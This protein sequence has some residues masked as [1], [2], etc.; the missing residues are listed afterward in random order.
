MQNYQGKEAYDVL[1]LVCDQYLDFA[2]DSH[3]QILKGI[4]LYLK[5][6]YAQALSIFMRD[7]LPEDGM[8][9]RAVCFLKTYAFIPMGFKLLESHVL[10][11]HHYPD[12]IQM[13]V[14]LDI[15]DTALD[16]EN[17]F[18]SEKMVQILEK[19]TKLP[20]QDMWYKEL[21]ERFI[22]TFSQPSSPKFFLQSQAYFLHGLRT[23]YKAE[24]F[25]KDLRWQWVN[26]KLS[27]PEL[28]E[29][30]LLLRQTWKHKPLAFE[31]TYLLAEIYQ[32]SQHKQKAL[33]EYHRYLLNKDVQKNPILYQRAW[34]QA[35]DLLSEILQQ[36]SVSPKEK[37]HTYRRYHEY[38][39]HE[40][41]RRAEIL[42][43]VLDAVRSSFIFQE[44]LPFIISE[45][46]KHLFPPKVWALDAVE[47]YRRLQRPKDAAQCMESW[48]LKEKDL[49]DAW[50]I[51]HAQCWKDANH[52]DK[53]LALL[54]QNTSI[55]GISAYVSALM[56]A[57]QW[58]K[59][60]VVT[61]RV[62]E[63]TPEPDWVIQRVQAAIFLKHFQELP[64]LREKYY[65]LM[66][67]TQKHFQ[68][69]LLLTH[70]FHNVADLNDLQFRLKSLDMLL[71]PGKAT[72]LA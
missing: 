47:I 29:R 58:Q 44:M 12:S 18:L 10:W 69:F 45:S 68:Q 37:I 7:D 40:L 38:F 17:R 5:Q 22:L 67:K 23:Y 24:A 1:S 64:L 61:D 56:D 39:P 33:E 35:S 4:S 16:F 63:K 65:V 31:A 32:N 2:Q 60:I 28:I 13:A 55:K 48:P 21:R 49:N 66:K 46:K 42:T 51:L 27:E 3:A 53:S 19:K 62:L 59:V 20:S 26:K 50:R 9:W 43:T 34:Y 11:I 14:G 52:H 8:F 71:Y 25:L 70:H 15:L 54:E 41:S 36:K 6:D 30:I 57:K 72:E